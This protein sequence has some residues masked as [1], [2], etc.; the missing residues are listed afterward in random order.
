MPG[1]PLRSRFLR[2]APAGFL[3]SLA[4]T[5]D[6]LSV[7]LAISQIDIKSYFDLGLLSRD[8]AILV[9]NDGGGYVQDIPFGC[10]PKTGS[11]LYFHCVHQLASRVVTSGSGERTIVV[12]VV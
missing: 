6:G 1:V 5:T 12:A 4:E 2:P 3:I 9:G 11:S 8:T 7:P 10:N